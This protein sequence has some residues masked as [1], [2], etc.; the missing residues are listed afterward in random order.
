MPFESLFQIE[1]IISGTNTG[2]LDSKRQNT[3]NTPK[4]RS[5]TAKR[6]AID[7]V[8]LGCASCT[9]NDVSGIVKIMGTVK[10]RDILVL[11]QSPGPDE[12]D[13]R[14]EFVGQSGQ[15]LWKEL[16]RVGITPDDVDLQNA[17]RC[18][19]AD[20]IESSYSSYLKMRTPTPHEMKC[21]SV[22][23]DAAVSKSS[24]KQ[25]LVLGQLAAKQLLDVRSLPAGKIFWS[26]Q[27]KAKIYLA[28]HPSFFVRGGADDRLRAFRALLD[29]LA[30]DRGT[31]S[32]DMVDQYAFLRKQKYELVLNR[33]QADIASAVI[34]ANGRKRVGVDIESYTDEQGMHVTCC[35]FS[36]KPGVSFIFVFEHKDQPAKDGNA[37]RRV[38]N[39]LI[40]SSRV[41]KAMHY[42]CS[43]AT[44]YKK[45]GIT[46]R[47]FDHDT[48][49]S[50]Y[51][52]F[53][54]KKKYGL[55]EISE[56]RF[57][58]F[59][60][61][62][63]IIAREMIQ[64]T[65]APDRIMQGTASE[66]LKWIYA[67]NVFDIRKLSLDTLRLYNGADCDITKRIELDNKKQVHQALLQLYIDLSFV[68][69]A[70]EPNGPLFDYDQQAMLD[71]VYKRREEQAIA[72]IR[73]M[74]G[75]PEFNPASPQ[76][77]YKVVYEDLE[78]EYPFRKGKPDTRK[79]TMRM[80]GRQHE[81]PLKQIACRATSKARS[82]YVTGYKVVADF[83]KGR[84][85]TTWRATGTRTGRLSS[86]GDRGKAK[87]KVNLQNIHGDEQLQNMCIADPRW[88]QAYAKFS[89]IVQ[90][91]G[92]DY[93]AYQDYLAVFE[94]KKKAGVIPA[95]QK[96]G[97]P[98][99]LV[100]RQRKECGRRFIKWISKHMP[101][102]K[103]F[104]ILDY[105]Q[106]EVRVM[107]QMSGDKNLIA[108][109]AK[110][111]IHTAVGV[112]MTGWDADKIK[113][114]KVTRT[115]TKNVHFGIMFGIAKQNLFDFVV[116]MSPPEM[117]DR[118]TREQIYEAYDNYFK[119]YSGVG[120]YIDAQRSSAA[121]DKCV[122]TMFH[123]K[124]PLTITDGNDG[125]F[126][127]DGEDEDFGSEVRAGG[128]WANQ[129]INGPVQGTAHQLME[130]ALINI[131][132]QPEKYAILGIPCMD[133]H[134]ALYMMVNVLD[135]PAVYTSARYLMEVESLNTVRQDFPEINWTV[136]I[137]TEAEAGLRLGCK[138]ELSEGF[139]LGD[140]MI[141]WWTKC[142]KQI[143]ALDKEFAVAS[144]EAACQK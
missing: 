122:W 8:T 143:K 47:G 5:T 113:N 96:P 36:P 74:L 104:F 1:P 59:S 90:E 41:R 127:F 130:C 111:D 97:K 49:L 133:V 103:T 91:H 34:L 21:C 73:E 48:M 43:D 119:R 140:W 126:E 136:P 57:P 100:E 141:D 14:K 68:L 65:T 23:T 144:Q 77:V 39:K 114:D 135:L 3:A 51:L 116:A 66:Q 15:F 88:R 58:K 79:Q 69:Y 107:A 132:R 85:R 129:C 60:G 86:G 28:D 131:V 53:S 16:K 38:A 89:A 82:T 101:D 13:Q 32:H 42:G 115:L 44:S 19:P 142:R 10:G 46:L 71:V 30:A 63:T 9:L 84:L 118:I 110:A 33:E 124:Q 64:G 93:A 54:D 37:V 40:R 117:A 75:K 12:N 94:A 22:H 29:Q 62:K 87:T 120:D 102:L 11:G 92:S 55:E 45:V 137:V 20:L 52:R 67:N 18:F 125:E 76:Q 31:S 98:S 121:V 35:G 6:K 72:E 56:T 27:H 26:E 80:L 2:R 105:G 139:E 138:I 4:Q 128:Y 50:E 99:L 83:N 109:C 25:I 112:T 7:P 95:D 106:M 17:L 134:D 24:A 81:Y 123:M 70:M 61:Y 108:D 78:L